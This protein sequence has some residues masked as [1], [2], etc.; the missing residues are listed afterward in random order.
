MKV[1]LLLLGPV[2]LAV[3]WAVHQI[4]ELQGKAIGGKQ[5][6]AHVG[7]A[8]GVAVEYGLAVVAVA[9]SVLLVLVALERARLRP[10]LRNVALAFALATLY[11]YLA[12]IAPALGQFAY[13]PLR[14]FPPE[15]KAF[16]VAAVLLGVVTAAIASVRRAP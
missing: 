9:V 1:L 15:F 7:M 11:T 14:T 10:V 8:A 2:W 13:V 16:P 6:F 12:V 3:P 5:Y 4:V